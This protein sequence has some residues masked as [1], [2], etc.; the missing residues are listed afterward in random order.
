M[1]WEVGRTV[2][3]GNREGLEPRGLRD[4]ELGRIGNLGL[5]TREL[6]RMKEQARTKNE[7]A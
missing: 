6:G 3:G 5:V 7:G 4:S 2:V 1:K